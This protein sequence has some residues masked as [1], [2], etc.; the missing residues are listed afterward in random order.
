MTYIHEMEGEDVIEAEGT[1]YHKHDAECI[2]NELE[3]SE[4][5]TDY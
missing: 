1:C 4:T 2:L 3:Y 5:F